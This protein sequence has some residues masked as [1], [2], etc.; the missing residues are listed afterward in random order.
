MIGSS[1][2]ARQRREE[3]NKG[4]KR[5]KGNL[6]KRPRPPVFFTA[7][8]KET[9]GPSTPKES[10]AKSAVTHIFERSRDQPIESRKD[11]K[12]FVC[13]HVCMY[14]YDIYVCMFNWPK[15]FKLYQCKHVCIAV[16]HTGQQ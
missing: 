7:D 6:S 12:N 15:Q 10:V 1:S 4:G 2:T 13:N 5:R 11:Q 3:G 9:N 16:V 8:S 14:A